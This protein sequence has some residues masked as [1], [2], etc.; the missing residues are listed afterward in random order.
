MVAAVRHLGGPADYDVF[1]NSKVVFDGRSDIWKGATNA[2]IKFLKF[3]RPANHNPGLASP[4]GDRVIVEQ[5]IDGLNAP[6]TR[7]QAGLVR[8]AESAGIRLGTQERP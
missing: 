8:L 7:Q 4:D 1:V 6:L 3:P 2:L 5:V